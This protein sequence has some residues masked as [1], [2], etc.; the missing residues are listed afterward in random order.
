M[1]NRDGFKFENQ[2]LDILI[3]CFLIFNFVQYLCL[4]KIKSVFNLMS[5]VL[6]LKFKQTTRKIY[7]CFKIN[8]LNQ[9]KLYLKLKLKKLILASY[10]LLLVFDQLYKN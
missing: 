5:F 2:Y 6:K 10:F 1:F 8:L 9:L 7:I 3:Y 4:I